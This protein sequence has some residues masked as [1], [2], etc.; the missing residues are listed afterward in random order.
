[1][2]LQGSDNVVWS[3]IRRSNAKA[4]PHASFNTKPFFTRERYN[5]TQ[6]QVYKYSGFR[7]DV[8]GISRTRTKSKSIQKFGVIIS[9]KDRTSKPSTAKIHVP[10]DLG[11]SGKAKAE[12]DV[13]T[14]TSYR[15][16]RPELSKPA[17]DRIMAIR[18]CRIKARRAASKYQ[19]RRIRINKRRG[20][21]ARRKYESE[22]K[23]SAAEQK[24]PAAESKKPSGDQ[25]NMESVD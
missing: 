16:Y 13:R 23:K 2:Y 15:L 4:R 19:K 20:R 8:V 12:R 11:G 3:I 7:R 22:K 14:L 25:K 6:R 1:M 17:V 18:K 21:Y 24:Q 10:I 5:L 9:R